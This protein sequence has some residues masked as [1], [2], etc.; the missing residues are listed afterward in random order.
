MQEETL[1]FRPDFILLPILAPCLTVSMIVATIFLSNPTHGRSNKRTLPRYVKIAL[2]IGWFAGL[3]AA[4]ISWVLYQTTISDSFVRLVGWS[5]LG[6]ATGL[7]EGLSWYYLD[8]EAIGQ[9]KKKTLNR[10][11]KATSLGL[12]AGIIAAVLVEL[13][14]IIVDL[15]GGEDPLGFII[16]GIALGIC[17]NF[18]ANPTYK[19]AL[20][21][22]EGFE[23]IDPKKESSESLQRPKPRI[24]HPELKFAPA[25]FERKNV[26]QEGLSIPLPKTLEKPIIIGSGKNAHIYL[27]GVPEETA[28]LIIDED[29]V[30]ICPQ[31]DNMVQIQGARLSDGAEEPLRHNQILTFYHET[32]EE[33]SEDEKYYRFVFY[34]QFYEPRA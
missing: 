31:Q 11:K 28:E 6:T 12:L 34:N 22:G 5:I 23:T 9:S 32:D 17:I 1:P 26:I 16:L 15:G 20:R 3:L 10:I 7:A 27:P 29:G 14:R 13:I 25:K 24:N 8:K 18:A 2:A 30:K 21:A 33:S 4:T 19:I